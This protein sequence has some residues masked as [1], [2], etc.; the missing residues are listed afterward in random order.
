ME[1]DVADMFEDGNASEVGVNYKEGPITTGA[2][3]RGG[4]G[5]KLVGDTVPTGAS[6]RGGGERSQW[7]TPSEMVAL[8][9]V[10]QT[11]LM[12]QVRM[13]PLFS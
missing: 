12:R 3:S 4:G 9:S 11:V 1:E 5:E 7:E 6:S 8:K 10:E 2:S 13:V